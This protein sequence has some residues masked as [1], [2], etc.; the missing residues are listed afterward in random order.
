MLNYS[1]DEA[2]N[3][4]FEMV[5][6]GDALAVKTTRDV[7]KVAQESSLSLY[8]TLLCSTLL[9]STL[10]KGSCL[11]VL[12]MRARAHSSRSTCTRLLAATARSPRSCAHRISG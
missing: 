11:G 2:S 9:C 6:E 12:R 10:Q 7:T 1:G 8:P 4:V 5:D 3:V